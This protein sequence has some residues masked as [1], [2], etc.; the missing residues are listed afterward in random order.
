MS[1]RDDIQVTSKPKHIIVVFPP[2]AKFEFEIDFMDM[3]STYATSNAR[4]GLVAIGNFTKIAEVVPINITPEA[5]IDGLKKIFAPTGKPKQLYSD[6]E[7]SMRSATMIRFLIETEIK[8]VQ[9]T[10]HAHTVERFI[11]TFKDSL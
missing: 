1:K 3:E 11:I 6:D 8:S 4:H 2:G 9:T 7:S 10:S 5:L